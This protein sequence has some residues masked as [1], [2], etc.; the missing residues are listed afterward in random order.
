MAPVRGAI[1]GAGLTIT[2]SRFDITRGTPEMI[3]DTAKPDSGK[4]WESPPPPRTGGATPASSGETRS[5]QWKWKLPPSASPARALNRSLPRH[6]APTLFIKVQGFRSTLRLR[7]G[8]SCVLGR[9]PQCD[10][11]LTDPRVSWRHA[12]VRLAQNGWVFEDVGSTNGTFL[13][14]SQIDIRQISS[15][16]GFRLADAEDGPLVH[17]WVSGP[18]PGGV[19]VP[20]SGTAGLSADRRDPGLAVSRR[21]EP[22]D[23]GDGRQQRRLAD[24]ENGAPAKTSAEHNEGETAKALLDQTRKPDE[25]DIFTDDDTDDGAMATADGQPS[26]GASAEAPTRLIMRPG[27]QRPVVAAL[28]PAWN[29]EKFIAATIDGLRSQT[30]PPDLIVVIANNCTDDTAGAARAAGAEVIEMPHNPHRKA[31]ALN[32]GIETLL[33]SLRDK[34]RIF[35]MDADTVIV[36]RWF[37]LANAVMDADP[38]AVVSGRYA[39]RNA[40]GLI[41]LLQRNEFARECR[42]TDRRGDRTHILVGTST[43]LPVAMLREV[44]AARAS[45]TLP[46]GYVYLYDSLT[47]DFELTLAAKTLGWQTISPF[48]CDAATDTMPT[49]RTLWLQRIRWMQGGVE[50]LRRYGWTRITVPFHVRRAWILFGLGAMWLFYATVL[51]TWASAG[52]VVTSLPWALLTLVFIADRVSGVRA[53]GARSMLLAALLVPEVVY[54]MFAQVVYVTALYKAFRG[55]PSTWHET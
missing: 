2:S 44:I 1:G 18:Q 24:Q 4:W 50:D 7:S 19:D 13:D 23:P 17:C 28:V 35:V 3:V 14:G 42:M 22:R 55:G 10:I 12:A 53:Q 6:S 43:L 49:W 31:G 9:D 38:R 34:D 39:C 52:T 40:Q 36:P 5:T 48:G 8:Q 54:N 30:R 41:G 11:V 45:G 25:F 51:A 32:Y 37:E 26:D 46:P 29:E 15:S 33:A 27:R 20:A 16:S 21:A 47:E